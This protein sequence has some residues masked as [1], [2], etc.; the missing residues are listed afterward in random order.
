[1]LVIADV[2]MPNCCVLIVLCGYLAE[3]IYAQFQTLMGTRNE[4]NVSPE[5]EAIWLHFSFC[6]KHLSAHHPVWRSDL[7]PLKGV[8]AC[9][10][11]LIPAEKSLKSDNHLTLWLWY[12][13]TLL[14]DFWI[15]LLHMSSNHLCLASLSLLICISAG[16]SVWTL[17]T[18]FSISAIPSRYMRDSQVSML[19][20]TCGQDKR[21]VL[22]SCDV[23]ASGTDLSH[24]VLTSDLLA[25]HM[26]CSMD[27]NEVPGGTA[28]HARRIWMVVFDVLHC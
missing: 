12:I 5:P 18:S 19:Q 6:N 26:P 17:T 27:T 9:K 10:I 3:R 7:V 24:Q 23:S 13:Q 2:L 15:V 25:A 21:K 1:M 8:Q 22:S 11:Q 14:W 28:G 16:R 4:S 20:T